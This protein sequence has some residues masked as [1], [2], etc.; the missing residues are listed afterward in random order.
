MKILYL[1]QY[2][3]S[4]TEAGGTRSYELARRLVARGHDVTLI[5][6]SA[7]LPQ[8]ALD[9]RRQRVMLD[10]IELI[11]LPVEYDNSMSYARRIRSFLKFAAAAAAEAAR[12]RADVVFAT[13]TPLTI[14][15]PGLAARMMTRAPMVFE[16]RDLWPEVPIAMGALRSPLTRAAARGLEWV[17]YHGARE[18]VALSPGMADGVAKQGIPR[19]RITVIPNG[20]D[21]DLFSVTHE[22]ALAY[23]QR[24]FP[25]LR[26]DQPLCLYAGTLGKAHDPGWIV[27]LAARMRHVNPEVRFALVGKGAHAEDIKVRAQRAGVLDRNLWVRGPVAKQD[28]PKLLGSAS[29][30]ISTMLPMPELEHNSANKFF[31]ALAAGLPVAINYGGWQ[32]KLLRGRGAGMVLDRADPRG[33]AV[34]L[35]AVLTDPERLGAFRAGARALARDRFDRDALADSLEKVLLRASQQTPVTAAA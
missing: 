35:D 25:Q 10:G 20:C 8:Y 22:D 21:V 14:A 11:V 26:D 9:G 7:H 1:H 6:S 3:V 15:V 18:V 27:E 17:A 33:S 5:T 16:V 19:E 23:R 32:A 30:A 12:H 13:S 29:M 34:A 4:P 2:F 28:M 24:E 31:D